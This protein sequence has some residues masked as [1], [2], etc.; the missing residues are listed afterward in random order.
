VR[1][2]VSNGSSAQPLPGMWPEMSCMRR[3]RKTS[4]ASQTEGHHGK[5]WKQVTGVKALQRQLVLSVY[6]SVC[7]LTHWSGTRLL[8]SATPSILEPHWDTSPVAAPCHGDPVVLDLQDQPL[9]VLQQFTDGV[10]DRCWGGPT[11]SPG[12]GPGW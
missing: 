10:T 5:S 11:Q 8:V 9:H 12:S 3:M 1:T 7:S 6:L 2:L 4:P